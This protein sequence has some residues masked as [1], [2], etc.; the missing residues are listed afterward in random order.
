MA[1]RAFADRLAAAVVER[2]S[3]LVVGLDPQPRPAAPRAPR[4]RPHRARGGRDGVLALLPRPDRRD[5]PLRRRRQAAERVLRGARRRRRARVRGRLRV[6]ADGRAAR[7]RRRQ[8]RRHRL[9]GPRVRSRLPRAARRRGA[10]RRRDDR[11]RLSRPGLARA[12]RRRVPAV[13]PRDLLPRQDVEPRRRRRPGPE[14]DGRQR[15][16]G[17]RWRSSSP[18]SA[19]ASSASAGS[20]ASAPSSARPTRARSARRAGCSRRPILLLLGVGAQGATPADVARAFTSG[21]ASALVSVSRSIN[22]AFRG[23]GAD[24]RTA[25]AAEAARLRN[26]V[27]RASGW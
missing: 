18:S 5:L 24:W 6:R 26:E 20:R 1:T 9:D 10:A 13:G 27:W 7:D 15:S 25:A 23:D 21:P 11:Q 3:Q 14:A 8:A 22:Y 17:T 12:V 19:R 4:R 2:R 16:S